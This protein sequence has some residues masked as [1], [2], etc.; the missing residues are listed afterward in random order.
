MSEL[1]QLTPR[2]GPALTSSLPF[3]GSRPT[4]P[5]EVFKSPFACGWSPAQ[6]SQRLLIVSNP[7]SQPDSHRINPTSPRG[8]YSP[9]ASILS[10]GFSKPQGPEGSAVNKAD[11]NLHP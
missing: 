3:Q 2:V 9:T 6:A 8:H 1:Q 11:T 5:E 10:M 7:N 4:P